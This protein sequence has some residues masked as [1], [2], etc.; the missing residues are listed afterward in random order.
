MIPNDSAPH[1]TLADGTLC[2][3]SPGGSTFTKVKVE[4][5]CPEFSVG[6]IDLRGDSREM[7]KPL[8]QNDHHL[9]T[10]SEGLHSPAPLAEGCVGQPG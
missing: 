9:R 3:A 5:E 7:V 2:I 4:G 1:T 10:E 6:M 8:F